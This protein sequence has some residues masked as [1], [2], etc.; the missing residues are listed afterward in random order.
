MDIRLKAAFRMAAVFCVGLIAGG[1]LYLLTMFLSDAM[2]LGIIVGALVG[3]L[4]YNLYRIFLAME[5]MK[6]RNKK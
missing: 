2:I 6:E 1:V 5:E 4:T 3:I